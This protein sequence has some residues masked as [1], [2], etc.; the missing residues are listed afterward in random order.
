MRCVV[1]DGRVTIP[2]GIGRYTHGLLA[3]MLVEAPEVRFVLLG[4]APSG[5]VAPN[6]EEMIVST[7]DYSVPALWIH[8]MIDRIGAD[9]VHSPF[10]L[11]PWLL[12]TPLVVTVHDLMAFRTPKLVYRGLERW[13]TPLYHR[14]WFRSSLRRACAVLVPTNSVAADVR[15]EFAHL[16]PRVSVTSAGVEAHFVPPPH[17]RRGRRYVLA[18]GN[19]RPYK[20]LPRLIEAFAAVAKRIAD[21]DLCLVGRHGARAGA[22]ERQVTKLGIADRVRCRGALSD[23]DLVQLLGGASALAFPSLYEGFGLPIIEAMAVGC[24]VIT[25]NSGATAEV[26]G[27][28]AQL[29]DPTRVSSIADAVE[30]LLSDDGHANELRERGL[31]RSQQFSWP[32]AARRTLAV[33]REVAR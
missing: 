26:A 14:P 2:S 27:D 4:N 8:R 7:P 17:R 6:L 11:A 10:T 32:A 31:A 29:C 16:A 18:Y 33:Y 5:L 23:R 20:N 15:L 24:P 30:A 9:V 28:A 22:I 25:A 21:V 1:I 12:D 19:A 13:V 3:A